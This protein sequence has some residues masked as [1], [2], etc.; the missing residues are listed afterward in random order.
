MDPDDIEKGSAL[1]ARFEA[2]GFSGLVNDE[3]RELGN[4]LDSEA[5]ETGRAAPLLLSQALM[6]VDSLFRDEDEYGGV[7]ADFI[8]QL[9]NL[10]RD[11]FTKATN[12]DAA[13][14]AKLASDFRNEL[15][16]RINHYSPSGN[17]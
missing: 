14:S 15:R 13:E 11:Y 16:R 17:Y 8:G 3:L 7:Q 12:A 5:S 1:L 4:Y 2:E 6:S 10:V 9:N